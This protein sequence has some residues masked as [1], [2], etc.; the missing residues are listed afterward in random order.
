M[1]FYATLLLF[2]VFFREK[3][4]S[5]EK[6]LQFV[7]GTFGSVMYHLQIGC[8]IQRATAMKKNVSNNKYNDTTV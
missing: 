6:F 2:L 5:R 8:D 3:L 7:Y 1:Q 4:T